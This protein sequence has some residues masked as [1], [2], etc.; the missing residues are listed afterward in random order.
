MAVRFPDGLQSHSR[1]T[2]A[3]RNLVTTQPPAPRLRYYVGETPE[4][5]LAH[6]MLDAPFPRPPSEWPGWKAASSAAAG[7]VAKLIKNGDM[8]RRAADFVDREPADVHPWLAWISAFEALH[9]VP[10]WLRRVDNVEPGWVRLR[11]GCPYIEAMKRWSRIGLKLLY[12]ADR[13]RTGGPIVISSEEWDGLLDSEP[14]LLPAPEIMAFHFALTRAGLP[15][16]W[17]GGNR[18]VVGWGSR[19]KVIE[20]ASPDPARLAARLAEDDLRIPIY[21]VTG[22]VGKTTTARFL[23]QLFEAAGMAVGATSSDGSWAAGRQIGK[24]DC[25]GGGD[26]LKLLRNS[27]IDVAVIEVGRGGIVGQGLPYRES[28]LAILLNVDAVHLGVDGIDTVEQMADLKGMTLSRAPLAILNHQDME[29]RRLGGLRDPR[30]CIWFDTTAKDDELGRLSSSAAGAL[31]VRRTTAGEPSSLTIWQAGRLQRA[32]SL[33][34][35]APYHGFLGEKTVEELLVAVG[36][37][38]FGPVA[39]DGLENL[40]RGL[41]LDNKNHRFRTSIHR[42]GNLLFVLD[43]AGEEAS[44]KLLIPAL[45]AIALHN[46]I[47]RRLCILTRSASEL[48]EFHRQSCAML[49]PHFDEFICFDRPDTYT[50]VSAL[51]C[52]EPGSIPVLLRQELM[53]LNDAAGLSKPVHMA[54]DWES[55]E[56]FFDAGSYGATA[57]T[58]ILVNQPATSCEDLNDKILAFVSGASPLDAVGQ[59]ID[60]A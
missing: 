18:T 40:L 43:K 30:S 26:A 27:D 56:R 34:G 17:R 57:R 28:D 31:G 22:S 44:L 2:E 46:G 60:K 10:R 16:A 3:R 13:V 29:C 42:R 14:L 20:G 15:W 24:G 37:A 23:T 48:P 55:V 11:L 5:A 33:D 45:D 47:S 21:T 25:I 41:R 32:L 6:L 49:H 52:Y 51:P 54:K 39:V 19:R 7:Q 50:R 8:L 1:P 35:V 38:W 4:F 58:M 9:T 36:G 12:L 59:I 53:R